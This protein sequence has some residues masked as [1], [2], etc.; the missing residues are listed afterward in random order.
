[1]NE[2]GISV[3]KILIFLVVFSF[4]GYLAIKWIIVRAHYQ[5]MK[6]KVIEQARFA[7]TEKDHEIRNTILRRGRELHIILY[8]EDI[9]IE[10]YPGED[11]TISLS[12]PD[13]IIMPFHTFRFFFEVDETAPL[14]R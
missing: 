4:I 9:F 13:S 8:K 7:G 10:R 2:R 3:I 12:Y 6:D 11:I 5:A 14:P 1:M